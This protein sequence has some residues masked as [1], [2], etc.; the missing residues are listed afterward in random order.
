MV[1]EFQ[2]FGY[3][4]VVSPN[5]EYKD[6]MRKEDYGAHSSNMLV[7]QCC[8]DSNIQNTCKD[9]NGS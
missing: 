7:W 5:K 8:G 4:I 6:E 2:N 1:S 9:C 3:M